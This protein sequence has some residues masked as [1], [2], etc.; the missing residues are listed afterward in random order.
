MK[1]GTVDNEM[2]EL[3]NQLSRELKESKAALRQKPAGFIMTG[4]RNGR[5]DYTYRT[6]KG[7]VD[8][9]R[10]INS[11]PAEVNDLLEKRYLLEK[12][13]QLE[14]ATQVTN[15]F[16]ADYVDPSDD[17]VRI[18][19]ARKYEM[20]PGEILRPVT[21]ID[22]FTEDYEHFE[23]YPETKTQPTSVGIMV[24]SKSEALIAESL[25]SAGI[26]FHYEEVL[27]IGP[28]VLYPDF[29]CWAT[30]GKEYIWEHFGLMNSDMYLRR[31]HEKMQEYEDCGIVPWKNMI[32]TFDTEDGIIDMK[33]VKA[34]I[35]AWLL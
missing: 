19:L 9:R 15:Q 14:F 27:R 17:S 32:C 4:Q 22:T 10:R 6:K 11:K 7:G 13:R 28:Y 5:R 18:A 8:R 29:H 31:Y 1:I 12:V 30:D 23:G 34:I 26:R 2:R 33:K 21:A 16:I 3:Q 25:V 35:N 24:R 20:T